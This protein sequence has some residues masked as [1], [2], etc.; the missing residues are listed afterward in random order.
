MIATDVASR[1]LD[2]PDVKYVINWNVPQSTDDYIHRVGRTA[3]GGK[4]GTAITLMTQ[5]DVQKVLTLEQSIG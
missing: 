5:F 4:R 3:R 1:G 2:I